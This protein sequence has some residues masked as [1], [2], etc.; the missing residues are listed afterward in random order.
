MSAELTPSALATWRANPIAFVEM[1][2]VNPETGKP[3][4]LL[5]AERAFLAHAF[6]LGD[7]GKLLY[8][9]QVYSCP[10][11]SGKTTFAA[12]HVL[13]LTLLFGGAYPEATCCA[14]DQEQA[15]GRVFEMVRRIVE[16]SPVLKREAKLTESRI[17]FPAFDATITA[18][19]SDAGSAAGGNQC[20][21]IFD[22]LWAYVSERSRRLWDEM[23]PPPTRKIACRLT[24]TYAG[25]EGESLLLEEL[26]KRGKALPQVGKDLYA[27]DGLLMFWSHEP[28]APWQDEAWLASMRN[29]LRP[30]AYARMVL[31]EF[32]SSESAFV[33]LSAWDACVVPELGPL[34]EDKQLHVWVGVD[35]SVRRD[36]T[37][38]VACAYHKQA[39]CVRLITHRVFTPSASDPIDFEATVEATLLEWREKFLLRKVYFDPFQMV[40]VAQRL[41]R[42]GG[43]KIEEFA[44]TVPNLTAATQNLYDLIQ[45]RSLVLYPDAAMR[46]AIS[47]AVMHE[48]AR[49]WR[50]DKLKQAH[51]IDVVVALSM[52]ALAAVRGQGE[53]SYETPYGPWAS[54][55]DTDA[56]A[57]AAVAAAFLEAR[58]S[59]HVLRY[60]GGGYRRW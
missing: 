59:E 21:A 16:A 57:D 49:G 52:A 1:V 31:N 25:F 2:L 54:S 33:D 48:S 24:V 3:F 29:T 15:R 18:I 47:R 58:M 51:K 55:S 41:R 53:S 37:A 27:G 43:V 9:E 20:A 11:K 46:L 10:K 50:L 14:N 12:L 7:N 35:A 40:S 8:P 19:A 38:L 28:V 26:H 17:T 45:S 56:D 39:K 34:R 22:E 42:A 36:S 60:A 4:E 6:K 30:S 5:P 44:Q 23:V 32:A 13:T